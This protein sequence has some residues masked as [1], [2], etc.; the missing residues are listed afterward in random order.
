MIF[1]WSPQF[2]GEHFDVAS[3]IDES[4][5]IAT[6]LDLALE[7]TPNSES[8][9]PCVVSLLESMKNETASFSPHLTGVLPLRLSDFARCDLD[10]SPRIRE[11]LGRYDFYYVPIPVT[12]FPRAGWAFT[13]LECK[14][15]FSPELDSGQRPTA[16]DTFPR[17]EWMEILG[18]QDGLEI[19]LDADLQFSVGALTA[20]VSRD[21]LVGTVNANVMSEANTMGKL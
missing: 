11:L 8:D 5:E 20:G 12:L 16:F 15:S 4:I 19:G 6:N 14:V 3:L 17:A 13:R 1:D 18:F 21:G 10:P 7:S 9:K 2:S